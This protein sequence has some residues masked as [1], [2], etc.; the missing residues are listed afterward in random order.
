MYSTLQDCV[1]STASIYGSSKKKPQR[2]T[3][4]LHKGERDLS[5]AVCSLFPWGCPSYGYPPDGGHSFPLFS[6]GSSFH[7]FPLSWNQPHCLPSERRAKQAGVPSFEASTLASQGPAT[8][9]E[10][11]PGRQQPLL[12][13]LSLS[14]LGSFSHVTPA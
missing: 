6:V 3:G 1:S 13:G 7:L 4:Q 8:S 10:V 12:Q 2:N 14:C 9:S 5:L 11:P